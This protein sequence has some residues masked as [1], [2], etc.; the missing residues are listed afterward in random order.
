MQDCF[1]MDWISPR[2]LGY[3]RRIRSSHLTD[4]IHDTRRLGPSVIVAWC[5]AFS[6]RRNHMFLGISRL[7]L[8]WSPFIKAHIESSRWIRLGWALSAHA[9]SVGIKLIIWKNFNYHLDTCIRVFSSPD[10]NLTSFQLTLG[11]LGEVAR[12]DALPSYFFQQQ[13]GLRSV[14]VNTQLKASELSA[15][16][17]LPCLEELD[18]VDNRLSISLSDAMVI[19]SGF[20]NL[21]RLRLA[22]PNLHTLQQMMYGYRNLERLEVLSC[23]LDH[24]ESPHKLLSLSPLLAHSRLKMLHLEPRDSLND[25]PLY[26]VS[27]DLILQLTQS[28]SQ[29]IHTLYLGILSFKQQEST[30]RGHAEFS[31][32]ERFI[33]ECPPSLH[34]L[35][36]SSFH[37]AQAFRVPE[38]LMFARR[39]A[40]TASDRLTINLIL[41]AAGCDTLIAAAERKE[42]P[43]V[44]AGKLHIVIQGNPGSEVELSHIVK[45]ILHL[46]P[47]VDSTFLEDPE[48]R[49][50]LSELRAEFFSISGRQG[51]LRLYK[52]GCRGFMT[53]GRG[54]Y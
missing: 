47:R 36:L 3:T 31:Q 1:S 26:E 9:K 12:A 30:Y 39:F 23:I 41:D 52:D 49:R 10:I 29:H 22:I 46:F 33:R 11:H 5:K 42:G 15:L 53:I 35:R 16:A 7:E 2:F 6:Q 8:S 18:A 4:K 27:F 44:E 25:P 28:L 45:A 17:Q 40:S 13:T 51:G 50:R 43:I 37:H 32:V 19:A 48:D 14:R 38:F 54:M 34:T 21:R 24:I 20:E